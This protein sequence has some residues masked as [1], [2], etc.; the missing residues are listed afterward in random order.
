MT[1]R[2]PKASDES[3]FLDAVQRSRR[4]H[5]PWLVAP[6]TPAAVR[7]FLT[8]PRNRLHA[9]FLILYRRHLVGVVNISEIVRG[10]FQ[11]AYLGYYAF[12]PMRAV[13]T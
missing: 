11:S 5:R 12:V 9:T 2:A 1:I 8:R 6:S 7:R 3:A 13:D 4:L 10:S